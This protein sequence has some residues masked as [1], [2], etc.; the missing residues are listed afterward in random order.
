MLLHLL[1]ALEAHSWAALTAR[2]FFVHVKEM[3][4]FETLFWICK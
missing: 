4:S 2:L 3:P 1:A